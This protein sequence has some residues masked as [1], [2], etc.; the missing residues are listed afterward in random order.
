MK[1]PATPLRT[2]TVRLTRIGCCI[3]EGEAAGPVA[4]ALGER[5]VRRDQWSPYLFSFRASRLEEVRAAAVR[6]G[7]EI[8][9]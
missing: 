2:A 3:I 1:T 7:W 8:V 4:A 5:P 6:V 9:V